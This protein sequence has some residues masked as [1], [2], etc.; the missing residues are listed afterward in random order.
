M[1]SDMKRAR[2][3]RSR[4]YVVFSDKLKFFSIPFLKD[5]LYHFG[6]SVESVL[7]FSLLSE[8]GVFITYQQINCIINNIIFIC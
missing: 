7:Y 5:R 6:I 4:S 8:T 1:A 2:A 3:A